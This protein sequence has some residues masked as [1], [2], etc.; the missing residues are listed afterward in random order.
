MI[1]KLTCCILLLSDYVSFRGT[2]LLVANR[3]SVIGMQRL[4]ELN[5]QNSNSSLS[6]RTGF[7]CRNFITAKSKHNEVSFDPQNF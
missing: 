6:I 5:S 7:G 2:S 4:Y 1:N 3:V